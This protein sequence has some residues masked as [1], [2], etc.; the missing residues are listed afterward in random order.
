[1]GFAVCADE[2]AVRFHRLQ[3]MRQNPREPQG[4]AGWMHSPPDII[5]GVTAIK[6]RIKKGRNAG[7]VL[8]NSRTKQEPAPAPIIRLPYGQGDGRGSGPRANLVNALR[9]AAQ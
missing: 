6:L 4:V 3:R 2:M 9:N 1:M 7:V 8:Q 5:E